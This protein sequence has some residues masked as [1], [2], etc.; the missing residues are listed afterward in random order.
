MKQNLSEEI[1]NLKRRLIRE[2]KAR[3]SAE[4]MLDEYAQKTFLANEE[5]RTAVAQVELKQREI[6]FFVKSTE[7][8]TSAESH[9]T[10]VE[11]LLELCATFTHAKFAASFYTKNGVI[12]EPPSV[13][14][15]HCDAIKANDIASYL[16]LEAD[17]LLPFWCVQ[18]IELPEKNGLST[19]LVYSNFH[20][21]DDM[22]G[23]LTM[24]IESPSI[25]EGKLYLLDAHIAQLR[26]SLQ[27]IN[28][29]AKRKNETEEI[30]GLKGELSDARKQLTI[31]DRMSSIGILA[32]GVAH[33]INNPLAFIS[34]NNRYLMQVLLPAIASLRE[35][36]SD[37]EESEVSARIRDN[38]LVKLEET[39]AEVLQDNVDGLDRLGK[40]S[41][42]LRTFVH[43]NT[44]ECKLADLNKVVKDVIKMASYSKHNRQ[45]I[46]ITLLDE[47]LNVSVNPGEIEQVL[48]NIVINALH[49][50]ENS[51]GVKISLL[52]YEGYCGI[53]VKDEGTGISEENMEKIFSP[54]FT[55]KEVGEGT[56]LGLAISKNII[57]AHD[58]I[59]KV[60]STIN[61]GTSFTILLPKAKTE[62]VVKVSDD[63]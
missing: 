1:E 22:E 13:I 37:I 11:T 45:D 32:S 52:E 10:L 31:A 59:L 2:K 54:F 63:R 61:I 58:G 19:W 62:S 25:D 4:K 7:E 9:L 43:S 57:E 40:I 30:I 41:E 20:Y 27:K 17:S 5:L 12:C 21:I 3:K 56:G 39:I 47:P 48:L 23:W 18:E 46:Q 34:A 29:D 28:Q 49:A 55:T 42:S 16:P 33:E 44:E 36:A 6:E 26:H 15:N 50:T 38:N 53:E 51:G 14:C 8:S 35:L 60:E 24:L